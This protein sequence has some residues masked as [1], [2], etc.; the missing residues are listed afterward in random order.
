MKKNSA[1]KN[2]K[3]NG[4]NEQFSTRFKTNE[5]FFSSFIDL[6]PPK[7]Y[8]NSDD[9]SQWIKQ[10]TNQSK[11]KKQPEAEQVK[12][13]D[14][15][16]ENGDAEQSDQEEQIELGNSRYSKF[17]PRV[18]KT[19]SQIFKDFERFEQTNKNDFNKKFIF[20]KS[21]IN[22]NIDKNTSVKVFNKSQHKSLQK[23]QEKTDTNG[24]SDDNGTKS[25]DNGAK[26]DEPSSKM[27]SQKR[28]S[29]FKE[30][31]NAAVK[32]KRQ[33]YDSTNEAQI[34]NMDHEQPNTVQDRK[35]I[36]NKNGQVVFSKFD[37]TADKTLNHKKKEDKLTTTNAKP[38]DY[39]KLLKKLQEKREKVEE[40][41]QNEPEKANELEIKE[42]WRSAL[43]KASGLKVKDDV[44]MLKKAVKRLEKKKDKSKKNWVERVK[45]VESK[46]AQIQ[47]KRRKNIEKRRDKN[48]ET[49]IKKLKK[50]GRILPGF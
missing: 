1:H 41:K 2:G 7:I 37:F 47:D 31:K 12:E 22:E 5:E 13:N 36:L 33:R 21:L 9:H 18:F 27:T 15:N 32:Q 50:K 46:K 45:T 43:D 40:M 29:K 42:K 28:V 35:P 20:N 25:D 10:A 26:S 34:V 30:Q 39:K 8:L 24:V 19:V 11:K 44:T 48:K 49:K 6:I 14:E 38:K 3:L 17:D 23:S 16:K 4:I